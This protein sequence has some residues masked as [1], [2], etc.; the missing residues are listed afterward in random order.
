MR[1]AQS[2]TP[3]NSLLLVLVLFLA[4]RLT[5]AFDYLGFASDMGSHLMTRNWVL[6][7]DPTGHK[8]AHFRPPLYGALLVPFT[9]ALGD[10]MGAKVLAILA[11]VLLAIPMYIFSRRW[12]SPWWAVAAAL[13]LINTPQLA[14][15][16][17]G[18]QITLTS[19]AL[20]LWGWHWL[21]DAYEYPP[22]LDWY[23]NARYHSVLWKPALPIFLLMGTNQSTMSV[24][25]IVAGVMLLFAKNR[26]LGLASLIFAGAI[27][28]LWLPFYLV[29]L[30]GEHVLRWPDVPL[31]YVIV[32][33]D[34]FFTFVAL[35][36]AGLLSGLKLPKYIIWPGLALSLL[37]L[38][39][40]GDILLNNSLQRGLYI[41]PAFAAIGVA[42][43][44]QGLAN[45]AKGHIRYAIASIPL[46]LFAVWG[47]LWWPTFHDVARQLDILTP[48]NLAA[49]EWI[50][51]N[52]PEGAV[53]Y[54]TPQGL[55]WWTGGLAPRAW[56]G[57]WRTAPVEFEDEQQAWICAIGWRHTC[58]PYELRDSYNV[59]Y[60]LLDTEKGAKEQRLETWPTEATPWLREVW[61]QGEVRVYEWAETSTVY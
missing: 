48:D 3:F 60:L 32:R 52:T 1:Y 49:I 12:L 44:A 57:S 13:A 27:A 40:S 46:M 42:Y 34:G 43:A 24:F 18:N 29:H 22:S 23:G 14:D 39:N 51:E 11:S 50:G 35:V 58:D 8:L 33:G 2:L 37:A 31:V 20:A 56:Y 4:V 54:A 9:I 38:V 59:S 25:I 53:I 21:L 61:Q 7:D 30:P 36:G 55:G 28:G 41:A 15:I 45:S 10:L 5:L 26:G 47:A 6:G 17:A 19:L 16:L